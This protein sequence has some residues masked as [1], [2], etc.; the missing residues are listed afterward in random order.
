MTAPYT[1]SLCEDTG[2]LHLGSQL[3]WSLYIWTGWFQKPHVMFNTIIPC[4]TGS[5]CTNSGAFMQTWRYFSVVWFMCCLSLS[6]LYVLLPLFLC[7]VLLHLC[8]SPFHVFFICTASCF[9]SNVIPPFLPFCS[10]VCRFPHRRGRPAPPSRSH[11]RVSNCSIW[12]AWWRA[13]EVMCA[14]N[15]NWTD[16]WA[17]DSHFSSNFVSSGCIWSRLYLRWWTFSSDY[18]HNFNEEFLPDDCKP[19]LLNDKN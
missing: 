15:Y 10:L 2:V 4:C 17:Q 8:L 13:E 6:A 5:V 11:G 12:G 7:T 9:F 16:L 1:R 18:K 14:D 19:K 3:C